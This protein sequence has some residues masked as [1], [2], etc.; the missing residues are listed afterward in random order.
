MWGVAEAE[1]ESRQRLFEAVRTGI[2]TASLSICY[3][4]ATITIYAA[5]LWGIYIL[6]GI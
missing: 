6:T 5:D 3:N 1:D 4:C 2:L